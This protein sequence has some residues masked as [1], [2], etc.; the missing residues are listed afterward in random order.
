MIYVNE[1]WKLGIIM[2]SLRLPERKE[3]ILVLELVLG[4]CTLR[5]SILIHINHSKLLLI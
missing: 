2:T 4:S 5:R 1:L 3:D